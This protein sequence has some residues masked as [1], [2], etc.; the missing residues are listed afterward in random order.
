MVECQGITK[1]DYYYRLTQV[2]KAC[3][4]TAVIQETQSIV[5]VSAK[6][7]DSM[8]PSEQDPEIELVVGGIS[9]NVKNNTSPELLKMVL[10]VAANVE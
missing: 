5:P 7:T 4:E 6:L 9:I 3:L 1:A 10:E 2:R 8:T